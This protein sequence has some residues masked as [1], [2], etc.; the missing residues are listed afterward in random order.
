MPLDPRGIAMMTRRHLDALEAR[1]K[2]LKVAVDLT[3]ARSA[4]D[5]LEAEAAVFVEEALVMV[6]RAAEKR[7]AVEKLSR[8]LLLLERAW[9]FEEGLPG[10]GWMKSM[11]MSPDED[12]GY[13]SWPLPRARWGVERGNMNAAQ[14]GAA[15]LA[16]RL[17]RITELLRSARMEA[18]ALAP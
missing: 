7:E 1:A 12:S 4:C 3:E 17:G 6:E 14:D 8:T 5:V 10:R 18:A 16:V 2:V 13:A 11:Y 15:D 9:M